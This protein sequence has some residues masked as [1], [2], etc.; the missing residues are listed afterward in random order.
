MVPD[1]NHTKRR[2]DKPGACPGGGPKGKLKSEKKVMK[3]NYMLFHLYFIAFLVGNIIFSAIFCYFLSWAPLEK[4]KKQK[5]QIKKFQIFGPP[6]VTNSW[7]RYCKPYNIFEN[8]SNCNY[9]LLKSRMTHHLLIL[10]VIMD[11]Y[12]FQ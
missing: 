10:I 8:R 5:K 1:I 6:P 3:A 9:Y 7:T 2:I 12:R 4:L 11:Q